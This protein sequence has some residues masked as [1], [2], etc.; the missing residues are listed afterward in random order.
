MTAAV[1]TSRK[2]LLLA[3]LAVLF[4]TG[5]QQDPGIA[6]RVFSFEAPGR[7]KE[8][9]VLPAR[10]SD[11]LPEA[12]VDYTLSTSVELPPQMR[13]RPLTLSLGNLGAMVIARANGVRLV[14]LDPGMLDTYRSSGPVLFHVPED[15]TQAGV[16]RIELVVSHR[17]YKSAIIDEAPLLTERPYGPDGVILVAAFN[18]VSALGALAASAVVLL[19][20]S[21]VWLSMRGPR[22][23]PY[24]FFAIG[25]ACGLFYPE[26]LL[27]LTQPLFGAYDVPVMGAMLVTGSVAGLYFSRAYFDL[28]SPHRAWLAVPPL[29]V[30]VC[31]IGHN[32]F[33]SARVVG[34]GLGI[35]VTVHALA[36]ILALAR[37]QKTGPMSRN[38]W[39]IALAW[40]ISA[41]AGFPDFAPWFGLGDLTHGVRT[42]CIGIIVIA[43]YQA[44]ALS[45][46]HLL[47]LR[48]SDELVLEL[49]Q[50]VDTLSATNREVATLN[51][52]LRRQIGLRSKEL[53]VRLADMGAGIVMAPT[54]SPG[55]MFEGR[56]RVVRALG[57]GGMGAVYEVERH[58]DQRKFALKVF[59]GG[60]S[61][62]R[63]RFAREAQICAEVKHANIVTIVDVDVAKQGFPFMVMELIT[64]GTTLFNVRR[65]RQDIP[66]TLGVLQ[67][68]CEG[69]AAIHAAGI[70]HRDLKP[71]NILMSRGQDGRR[72]TVKITDFGISRVSD[73]DRLSD[74]IMRASAVSAG[75]E[76][77]AREGHAALGAEI[78]DGLVD[79]EVMLDDGDG[80]TK[81]NVLDPALLATRV[82][83]GDALGTPRSGPRKDDLTATGVIFG[84]PQYMAGE[85]TEGTK[86]ATRSSD[87]FAVGIIAFELLVARR[88]FRDSPLEARLKG[89][90][91]PVA[92][93]LA[94]MCPELPRDIAALFDLALSHDPQVRPDAAAL[95]QAIKSTLA[96]MPITPSTD[97]HA[98]RPKTR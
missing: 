52:E 77:M 63:A 83:K 68:V 6:L 15:L 24:G 61:F 71:S 88:P 59:S 90:P 82:P 2:W 26:F 8:S 31:A 25:A 65:R 32:P 44:V 97:N 40:P 85:L 75:E 45:R 51:D 34:V 27:G 57:A 56:Y 81:T 13:G 74:M 42:A 54:L 7:A 9:V 18:T 79:L 1:E 21:F 20:Y 46:E 64:D 28:P 89:R 84:T 58:T 49:K 55:E 72:P 80:D 87:M 47:A 11:R 53:A 60:D 98:G 96:R 92:P 23:R 86:G 76:Q 19:L 33:Y 69:I 5:C 78:E 16:V 4:V 35:A 48:R 37:R 93:A 10:L 91:M 41:I 66:W 43:I 36:Q 39:P 50:K 22:R 94:S 30:V 12:N 14:P 17:W 73:D 95:A 67:S 70:I 62:A 38:L 3:V 29:A